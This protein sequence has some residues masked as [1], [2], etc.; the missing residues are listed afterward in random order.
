LIELSFTLIQVYD[1]PKSWSSKFSRVAYTRLDRPNAVLVQYLGDDTVAAQ[2]P[3]G[4]ATT[5]SRNY[6][7]TQPHVLTDLK[8]ASDSSSAQRVYQSM[9]VVGTA[10]QNSNPVTAVPRN[11]QQVRNA[12]KLQRSGSR[13]SPW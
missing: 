7:R 2:F 9:V 1:G 13:L 3:H 12:F 5:T 6:V 4:N 8:K 10:S 11:T